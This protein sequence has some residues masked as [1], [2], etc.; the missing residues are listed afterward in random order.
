MKGGRVP[1]KQPLIFLHLVKGQEKMP[2]GSLSLNSSEMALCFRPVSSTFSNCDL[3]SLKKHQGKHCQ[4]HLWIP[5]VCDFWIRFWPQCVQKPFTDAKCFHDP[6]WEGSKKLN[7]MSG[8]LKRFQLVTPFHPQ[9]F[10]MTP[11]NYNIIGIADQAWLTANH[12]SHWKK[13]CSRL[14]YSVAI[15]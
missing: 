9:K 2:L 8:L 7:S 15:S 13:K 14:P 3:C 12:K 11:G 1:R 10:Y 6:I 4:K 5:S